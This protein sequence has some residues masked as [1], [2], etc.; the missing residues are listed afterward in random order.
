MTGSRLQLYNGIL[1]LSTFFS[2]RLV[3]GPY[4]SFRVF[5]DMYKLMGRHPTAPG[6]GVMRFATTDTVTPFW[7][8]FSYLAS[9]LTLTFLNFYWFFMMI[10]AVRKRFE[11]STKGSTEK[12]KV[13]AP[14]TEVELDIS[15][16]ASA[17]PPQQK[18]RSRRA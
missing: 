18:A 15:A 5:G 16:S 10:K 3:Y 1:L 8:A 9:N 2:A 4:Q 14:I 13:P 12:D 17:I 11:P 7:L 6:S